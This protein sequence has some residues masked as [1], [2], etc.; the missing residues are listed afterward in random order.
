LNSK[1]AEINSLK[2][3]QGSFQDQVVRAKNDV[4]SLKAKM[5]QKMESVDQ[6]KKTFRKQRVEQADEYDYPMRKNKARAY[7]KN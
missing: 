1:Q 7:K 5:G 6:L 3:E 2:L 4:K